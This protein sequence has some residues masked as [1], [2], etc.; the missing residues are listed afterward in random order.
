M[1][2]YNIVLSG[3]ETSLYSYFD[4]P[5][6]LDSN[7]K[8]SLAL[9]NIETYHSFPNVD[10]TNNRFVYSTDNGATWQTITVPEGSYEITDLDRF[11]KEALKDDAVELQPN[12]NTLK[13][14]L[15]ISKPNYSV[16]FQGDSTLKE[17]LGFDSKIYGPG[18][19][20]G[21]N[22]VDI[23]KV[24]SILVH[25]DLIGGSYVNGQ[26][27]PTL[28]SFFANVPPGYKIVQS[29]H[30]LV[31]LPVTRHVI[32]DM[33]VWLTDQNNRSLNLRGET[34]TVRLHLKSE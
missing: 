34:V 23:L 6:H 11:I 12:V 24:N 8:Y 1:E 21:V 20:E 22:N 19:H 9:V 33:R 4:T 31:Y 26:N 32:N 14:V 10:A 27:F 15:K 5:I 28:Y 18:S 30:N 3:S 13:C 17:M 29:P 16:S 2:S 7:R 25:C